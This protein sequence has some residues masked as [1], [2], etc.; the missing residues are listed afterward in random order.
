MSEPSGRTR[1][2]KVTPKFFDY[3]DTAP[4]AVKDIFKD[5]ESKVKEHVATKAGM[6]VAELD[7]KAQLLAERE[8]Q[9][10]AEK[11]KK[12]QTPPA[13][14]EQPTSTAPDSSVAEA[15]PPADLSSP[16]YSLPEEQSPHSNL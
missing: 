15:T 13:S 7:E 5:V 11:D 4:D 1:I 10:Q 12:K 3:F 2:L 14:S 9:Q 16:S 8:R 6:T